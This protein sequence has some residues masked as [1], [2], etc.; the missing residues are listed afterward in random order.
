MQLGALIIGLESMR[1]RD[2]PQPPFHAYLPEQILLDLV[3]LDIPQYCREPKKK[4]L[5]PTCK[6]IASRLQ[7]KTEALRKKVVPVGLQWQVQKLR[8]GQDTM[9][10]KVQTG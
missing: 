3:D 10:L 5:S 8:P 1:I 2:P 6:G 9:V 4:R 7:E